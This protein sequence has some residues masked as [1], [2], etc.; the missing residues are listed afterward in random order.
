VPEQWTYFENFETG[1]VGPEWSDRQV[2]LSPGGEL[3]LGRF[4]NGSVTLTLADLPS[5]QEATV[6]FDL[7]LI[8]SWDGNNTD[9]GPDIVEFRFGDT[10][11][12]RT[13]FSNVHK[14]DDPHPQAFPGDYPGGSF[15]AATGASGINTLG[16]PPGSSRYGDTKYHLEFTAAS[17]SST[18]TYTVTASNLQELDDESWGIDNVEVK[19]R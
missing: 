2:T 17:T 15:P 10:L 11:L 12:K 3:F 13:T 14:L 9:S 19:L 6:T 8:R 18:L 5:H 7:Y 16:Y 4:S 1:F